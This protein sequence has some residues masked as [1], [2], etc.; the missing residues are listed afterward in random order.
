MDHLTPGYRSERL[1]RTR[2]QAE[3]ESFL[4]AA[5]RRPVRRPVLRVLAWAT[6][7]AMGGLTA[8]LCALVAPD[9]LVLFGLLAGLMFGATR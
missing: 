3:A 2:H 4:L 5:S 8:V 6:I 7:G 9:G 1:A